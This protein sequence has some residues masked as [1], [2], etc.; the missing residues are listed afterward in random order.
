[1]ECDGGRSLIYKPSVRF[2]VKFC[3]VFTTFVHCVL[4]GLRTTIHS[5]NELVTHARI[6]RTREKLLLASTSRTSRVFKIP[7]CLYHPMY[8]EQV[9]FD[10]FYKMSWRFRATLKF[11][12]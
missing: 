3:A 12:I 1:M 2:V 4:F 6:L 9:L 10:F 5:Y 7:K 11:V 8:E